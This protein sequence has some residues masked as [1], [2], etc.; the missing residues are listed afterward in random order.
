MLATGQ[1]GEAS[2]ETPL[3]L[4]L[5]GRFKAEPPRE[6]RL[7]SRRGPQ[8]LQGLLREK[9]L[10]QLRAVVVISHGSPQSKAMAR[11]RRPNLFQVTNGKVRSLYSSWAQ[12]L[13]CR[14]QRIAFASAATAAAGPTATSLRLAPPPRASTAAALALA[15]AL[16]R[17]SL[18][19]LPSIFVP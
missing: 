2:R 17:A 14:R 8:R 19:A 10:G 11:S 7:P 5:I 6:D 4:L 1:I 12:C 15:E 16:R 3:L 9:G 13:R 18:D